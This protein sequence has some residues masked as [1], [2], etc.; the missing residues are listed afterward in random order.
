MNLRWHINKQLANVL[1]FV[2]TMLMMRTEAR[3][4]V[5]LAQEET[6]ANQL[7]SMQPTSDILQK[8][9]TLEGRGST[10]DVLR[11]SNTT[12]GTTTKEDAK[13]LTFWNGFIDSLS[14]IF[15][16]EFGDRVRTSVNE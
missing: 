6:V 3:K 16:V 13:K 1:L 11:S 9:R 8:A 12:N 5:L 15:F 7:R 2:L 4:D 14:M 10:E